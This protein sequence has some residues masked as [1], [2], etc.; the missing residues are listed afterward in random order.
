MLHVSCKV[1]NEISFVI[2]GLTSLYHGTGELNKTPWRSMTEWKCSSSNS[3]SVLGRDDRL[4]LHSRRFTSR[5]TAQWIWVGGCKGVCFD[6]DT[7]MV[8]KN[9]LIHLV[10][11]H[12]SDWYDWPCSTFAHLNCTKNA[13]EIDALV[14]MT[15]K[16][17]DILFT[18]T[19][20]KRE[21]ERD[22]TWRL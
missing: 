17:S 1:G 5:D 11:S 13:V 3:A 4:V 7:V 20:S 12:C 14:T 2:Y 15:T 6:L 16:P 22:K 21:L 8:K 10:A 9:F 19:S 18:G